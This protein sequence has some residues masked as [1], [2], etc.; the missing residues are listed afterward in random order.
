MFVRYID[1]TSLK[2]STCTYVGYRI[3]RTI[4]IAVST[5]LQQRML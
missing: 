1:I 5:V 4:G 2:H 3:G